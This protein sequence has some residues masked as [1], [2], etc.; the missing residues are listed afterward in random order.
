MVW[1][2]SNFQGACYGG[3]YL[4]DDLTFM[5]TMKAL[6]PNQQQCA[7]LYILTGTLHIIVTSLLCYMCTIISNLATS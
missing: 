1:L 5:L 3:M 4:P 7:L 2:K 6:R